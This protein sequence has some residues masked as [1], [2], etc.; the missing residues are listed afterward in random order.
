[1]VVKLILEFDGTDF[2]GWQI[3]PGRRTV[4][5][6]LIDALKNL[7]EGPFK[8]VGASRTDSGVHALN[9]VA[10]LHLEND[11]LKPPVNRLKEALNSILPEDIYIKSSEIAPEDFHARYSARSKV[12]LY[13][14]LS[15]PS[16]IRRRHGY[17]YPI[18]ESIESLN[19]KARLFLGEHDFTHISAR[20]DRAGVCRIFE[21]RWEM[22]GDELHYIVEGDRFLYKMVRSM[23][24]LMLRYPKEEIEEILKGKTFTPFMVPGKGLTLV[25]VKYP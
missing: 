8:L 16:P 4:Q 12:Y 24:G 5:G 15:Y 6:V 3:Q 23:V 18:D 10:S 11:I 13:R 25:E 20:S 21:S 7:T 14:I 9:F 22:R 19:E 2:Q 1:M 17:F